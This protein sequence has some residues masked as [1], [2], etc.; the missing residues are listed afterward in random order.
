M[1]VTMLRNAPRRQGYFHL[2]TRLDLSHKNGLD[3]WVRSTLDCGSL[4]PLFFAAA[5]CGGARLPAEIF[6][7]WKNGIRLWEVGASRLAARKRQQAARSPRKASP[8]TFGSTGL[9]RLEA[10]KTGRHEGVSV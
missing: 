1:N 10:V 7:R 5:C 8:S 9:V 4:L 2:L 6:G 3:I